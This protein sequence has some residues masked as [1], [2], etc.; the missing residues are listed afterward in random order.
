MTRAL[1]EGCGRLGGEREV[2]CPACGRPLPGRTAEP[3]EAA[4]PGWLVASER[5]EGAPVFEPLPSVPV[6]SRDPSAP[7]VAWPKAS[8]RTASS[9]GATTARSPASTRGAAATGSAA[10]LAAALPSGGPSTAARP[11]APSPAWKVQLRGVA[12]KAHDKAEAAATELDLPAPAGDEPGTAAL[13]LLPPPPLPLEGE[14]AAAEPAG[15]PPLRAL[16][17]PLLALVVASS[18]AAVVLLLVHVLQG[19]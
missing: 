15:R 18:V 11:A 9:S 14:V 1:C 16:Y 19:R 8:P 2:Y 12:G 6:M 7:G 3:S 5:G 4:P 10:P 17:L 13:V